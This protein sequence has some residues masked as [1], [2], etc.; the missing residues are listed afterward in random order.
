MKSC[1]T[2]IR[3]QGRFIAAAY[4]TGKFFE[5]YEINYIA[6]RFTGERNR[7]VRCVERLQ[8]EREKFNVGFC[9]PILRGK[10][11][12][13]LL[14]NFSLASFPPVCY[15]LF[16]RPQFRLHSRRCDTAYRR[17][18]IFEDSFHRDAPYPV[19]RL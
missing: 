15:F 1:L 17:M 4:N 13:G 3:L 11:R 8:L 9:L 10:L 6:G 5:K 18:L 19:L 12:A 7:G 16:Y 14:R 2:A